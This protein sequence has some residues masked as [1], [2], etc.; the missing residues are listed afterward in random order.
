MRRTPIA[1]LAA[2]ALL[3]AC[4]CDTLPEHAL[5]DCEQGRVFAG[6]VATDILFVID[7]SSSMAQEQLRL[8]A[9][10]SNF[11]ATLSASPVADDFRIGVTNTSV[12]G[13]ATTEVKYASGPSFNVPYPAG[14]LVSVNPTDVTADPATWGE[15]Y[16][17]ASYASPGPFFHGPRSIPYQYMDAGDANLVADFRNDVLVGTLGSLREQPFEAMR[18]ALTSPHLDA[19]FGENAGFIRPG[20]RLAVIFISDED[21]CSGPTHETLQVSADCQTYGSL[22]T[23]VGEYADFLNGPIAGRV[24]DVVLGAVVGVTCTGGSCT[25]SRCS[26]DI[27]YDPP[28]SRYLQLLDDFDPARTALASICDDTFDAALTQ[29]ANVVLSQSL[30]L[31]GDVADHR[32]LVVAVEK[33]TGTVD[34][35]VAATGT[36]EAATADVI[37]TPSSDGFPARLTFQEGKGC[38]LEPGDR[39]EIDVICAG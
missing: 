38:T 26:T 11:I 15:F 1:A 29:F 27:P 20:A 7:D 2:V 31:S 13:F 24:R 12:R 4:A 18:L 3:H 16:W 22:L 19:P 9:A 17:T 10:L 32:L 5:T 30:P 25:N 28:A 35:S 21:D 34:C 6:S 37:Y 36:L 14:S 8:Q 23:P 39:I 33:A